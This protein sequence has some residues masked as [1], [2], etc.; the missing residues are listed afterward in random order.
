MAG[1]LVQAGLIAQD[2]EEAGPHLPG[3]NGQ[4]AEVYARGQQAGRGAGLEPAQAEVQPGQGGGEA[5]GRRIAQPPGGKVYAADVDQTAQE[6][7]RGQDDGPGL[8]ETAVSQDHLPGPLDP[9]PEVHRLAGDDGQTLLA[10]YGLLDDPGIAVPI[11]LET[12][13]AHGRAFAGV[14][15]AE[16]DGRPVGRPAHEPAQGVDLL[17]QV[18]L[19]QSAHGRVAG[20]GGDLGRVV[21]HQDDAAAQPGS[22]P[23]G[24]DPGVPPADDGQIKIRTHQPPPRGQV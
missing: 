15:S 7:A 4:A 22:G 10:G 21:G 1:E 13:G 20:E 2:G 11:D 9:G 5:Q 6:C 17:D 12:G 3:L 19:A 23:G 8:D 16:L 14:E 24:L 18:A